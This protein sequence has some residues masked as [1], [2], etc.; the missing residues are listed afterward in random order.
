MD[1]RDFLKK[2]AVV[3]TAAAG[4]AVLGSCVAKKKSAPEKAELGEMTY[5]SDAKFGDKVSVL[6]YG[7]MRWPMKEENG[8]KV[9]DQDQINR[10]V[11]HAIANG[12]TYFDTAPV[13]HSGLSERAT[14][15]ALS[16]HDR[17]KYLIA[18]KLSNFDARTHSREASMAM[19]ENSFKELQVDVIDYYLLHS[20]GADIEGFNKRYIDNGML[21]FLME[22]RENGKIRH[23]GFSFHG[24][25]KSFDYYLSLHQKYHWDFVQI[26]MNYLDWKY[27]VQNNPRNCNGTYLYNELEKLGIPV[28][29]ME[30]LLGGRLAKVPQ[31]IA[32]RFYQRDPSKSVASWAFRFCGSFPGV[33]SALSGMTYMEHLEDNLGTFCPLDPLTDEDFQFLDT[34]SKLM[35]EYPTIPCNDCKYCIPCPYGIDIPGILQH[36]NKCVNEGSIAAD[37]M[38]PEYRKARKRYLTT[39]AKAIPDMRQADKC[40]GCNQCVPK[41]P[42]SI[43]I[44]KQLRRIDRYVENLKKEA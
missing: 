5:R 2:S 3:A 42:Q 41:C 26:Q 16:R 25:A 22:E 18:T 13:Y 35:M 24:D 11:D 19:Y 36:Y 39:Y 1:R 44:P 20:L 8:E 34:V 23:L 37:K 38:D 4:T 21:D 15:I 17:S 7:C 43:D 14:G 28:V 12:I 27:A 6:G 9:L 10:L 29:I 40:I 33:M 32:D 30:P 31:A